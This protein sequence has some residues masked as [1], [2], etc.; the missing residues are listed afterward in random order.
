MYS[1]ACAWPVAQLVIRLTNPLEVLP[2]PDSAEAVAQKILEAA[3]HEPHE[4]YMDR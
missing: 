1:F 2:K 4:Q 3:R